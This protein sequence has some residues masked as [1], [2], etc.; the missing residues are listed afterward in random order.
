MSSILTILH[1]TDF[2]A[3][4]EQAFRLACLL[5][6]DQ[7]ARV[8]VLHVVP[9]PVCRGEEVARQQPNGYHEQLWHEH[10]LRMQSPAPDVPIEYRLEDGDPA[11]VIV[12]VA[13]ELECG[14]VVMGTHGRSG[15]SRLLLGSVAEKVLRQCPCPV[16]TVREPFPIEEP[17]PAES[18]TE[19]LPG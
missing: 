1:P 3:R 19:A 16:L 13:E 10:L 18:A 2:S 15:I 4:S 6:R 14:M 17:D 8:V 5:A 9:P 12:R 7:G 11:E